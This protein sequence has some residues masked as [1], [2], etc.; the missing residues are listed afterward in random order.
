MAVPFIDLSRQHQP[1]KRE[2]LKAT[3]EVLGSS[4][5]ILGPTVARFEKHFAER[6]NVKHAIGVNSGTDALLMTLHALGIQPGDEI[7]CPVFT[8]IATADVIA[9]MAAGV[10]FVDVNQ[11]YTLDID[12]VRAAITDKTRAIMAVHLYGRMADVEALQQICDE[13]GIHLIEDVC[14]ATGAEINGRAAGT[15]G[16]AGAFSF[17][18]TKNLGGFGDGGMVITNNDE[19]ADRLRIYRDHGRDATGKFLE[20]GYNS[21]LDALQAALLDIKLGSLD[22]DNADRIANAAFY[23]EHLNR[24]VYALPNP[25]P[26]GAHVYNL[27]TIRHPQRDQLRAF[28]KDRQVESAVYYPRPLHLEPCLEYLGYVEGHFPMAEQFAREVISIPVAPGLTRQE[29]DE[30]AHALDLFAQTFSAPAA[31]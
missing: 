5:Y 2:L 23:Y 13:Y 11:D 7:I 12:A 24:D 17:Y 9:R 27:F 4:A 25:S 1:I 3:E 16:I 21:R 19:L 28:L 6:M 15:F 30:V 18:P 29:L 31:G 26:D 10:V 14:Q 20:I 8:F 22:E